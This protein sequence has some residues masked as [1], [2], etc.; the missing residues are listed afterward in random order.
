MI[1][2]QFSSSFLPPLTSRFRSGWWRRGR[3]RGR[4]GSVWWSRSAPTVLDWSRWLS[5][6]RCWLAATPGPCTA[7]D[8]CN[9]A[10]LWVLNFN[11]WYKH[12]QD[13]LNESIYQRDS[14]GNRTIV[15]VL[16]NLMYHFSF[17]LCYLTMDIAFE[18]FIL[19]A[20]KSNKISNFTT[21]K[22]ASVQPPKRWAVLYFL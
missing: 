20:H 1:Q 4:A 13:D 10:Y 2:I 19:T 5:H 17:N 22:F 9:K 3:R 18:V 11:K 21:E 7:R 8:T 14:F 12:K 15:T 16:K 6:L